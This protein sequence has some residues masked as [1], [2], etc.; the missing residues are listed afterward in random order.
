MTPVHLA[1]IDNPETPCFSEI[2]APVLKI[3][4][5]L[6]N[7]GKVPGNARLERRIVANLIGYMAYNGWA[8]TSVYDGDDIH[9]VADMTAAMEL[10]FNLDECRLTF[11][12]EFEGHTATHGVVLVLGNGID[13]ISDWGYS[14]GDA[15]K[16]NETMDG[17]DAES[18][19]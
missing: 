2:V 4:T 7:G 16:F 14:D 12:R 18:F 8:V 3:D 9:A 13:I 15:D 5:A 1:P 10:I 19:G 11:S 6:Y 17:F